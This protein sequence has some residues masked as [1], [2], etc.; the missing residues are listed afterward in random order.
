[1]RKKKKHSIE[2]QHYLHDITFPILPT[3]NNSYLTVFG[4]QH[5]LSKT[6]T[7]NPPR[8]VAVRPG[9]NRSS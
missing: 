9:T 4:S 8:K 2:L 6:R 1:M 5:F 7:G 3:P